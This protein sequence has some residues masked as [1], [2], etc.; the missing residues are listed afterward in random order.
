[1]SPTV[2]IHSQVDYYMIISKNI[3]RM[4]NITIFIT[5]CLLL[6]ITSCTVNKKIT[7]YGNPGTQIYKPERYSNP[8]KLG[9]IDNSGKVKIKLTREEYIP[10]LLIYDNKTGRNYPIGLDFYYRSGI[11]DKIVCTSL[12][13]PGPNIICLFPFL[14]N[15]RYYCSDQVGF[16]SLD[17]DKDY[18]YCKHQQL[19]H[20]V[21]NAPYANTGER[22]KISSK[23]SELPKS[24]NKSSLNTGLLVKDY[25][26]ILQGEYKVEGTLKQNN[27]VVEIL[28]LR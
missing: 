18:R 22:R 7:F 26:K 6:S 2:L 3:I 21:P 20:N 24:E 28:L 16:G 19:N 15:M 8:T 14:L 12:V 25:G 4:K 5:F 17:D 27:K 11:L 10:Y 13:I 23:S 9:T 1:M